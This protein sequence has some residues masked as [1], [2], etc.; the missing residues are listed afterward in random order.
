MLPEDMK[1]LLCAF[2]ANGV[3]YL[4]VGTYAVGVYSEPRATASL[5]IFI[6]PDVRNGEAVYRALGEYGVPLV[7]VTAADFRD[8]PDAIFQIG[9]APGRVDI[10]QHIEGVG[11]DEAWNARS[12]AIAD[13]VPVHL[14]SV[15]HL[16]RYKLQSKD[17]QN[18]ADVHAIWETDKAERA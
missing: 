7:G 2:N 3:E 14:I 4:I 15:K 18:E 16:I 5:E 11:F 9:K 17:L 10:L 6:R 12:D 13:G 8:D 1:Q